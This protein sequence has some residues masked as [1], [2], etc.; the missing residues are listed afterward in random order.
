MEAIYGSDGEGSALGLPDQTLDGDV[1]A[2]DANDIERIQLAATA[3]R[4][5]RACLHDDRI[6]VTR[7][8][9][10]RRLPCMAEMQ[11]ACEKHVRAAFGQRF[12]RQ[13]RAP[14]ALP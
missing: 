8:V 1:V 6:A 2:F 12:E 7:R 9:T 3:R 14:D 10:H 13:A 11:M 5:R 4:S